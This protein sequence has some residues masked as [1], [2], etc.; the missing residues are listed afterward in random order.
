M[1][2]DTAFKIVPRKLFLPDDMQQY[3]HYDEALAIGFGQTNS[4]PS[5]VLRMLEWLTP[6]PGNAVLDVGSGSGWTS[7]LLSRLVGPTGKVTAVEI[8]PELVAIGRDNC[9]KLGIK[10]VDFQHATTIGYPPNAPYDRI[11]VSAGSEKI[12]L[13]LIDQLADNGVMVLP[14]NTDILEIHKNINDIEIFV[15]PGYV[16]VPFIDPK[17]SPLPTQN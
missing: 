11:L 12:P 10:D 7:A 3:A 17:V 4:Q 14:I 6:A 13:K 15:H 16:F 2:I 9:I 5:T 1:D 8:V